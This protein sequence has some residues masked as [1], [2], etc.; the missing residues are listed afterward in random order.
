MPWITAVRSPFGCA[1]EFDT[2]IV[3]VIDNGHGIPDDI[4]DRIFDPFF[5]TKAVGEGTGMGLDIV[6]RLVFNQKGE[7]EV[8]SEPGRDGIQ[9]HPSIGLRTDNYSHLNTRSG[10]LINW[11][12][13]RIRSADRTPLPRIGV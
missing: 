13:T 2:L 11:G 9:G 6:R 4:K 12:Q 7:I 1:P 10:R 5:T 8:E 3:S